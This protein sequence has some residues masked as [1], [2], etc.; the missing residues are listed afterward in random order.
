[1]AC[2]MSCRNV[3]VVNGWVDGQNCS[4]MHCSILFGDIDT[5]L[6]I[7]SFDIV[8]FLDHSMNWSI[9][10][11]YGFVELC[12]LFV[13]ISTIQ[14]GPGHFDSR[15]D[16]FSLNFMGIS[17]MLSDAYPAIGLSNSRFIFIVFG[18]RILVSG[19]IV[20]L[21]EIVGMGLWLCDKTISILGNFCL[22]LFKFI[23]GGD[24]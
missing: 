6:A 16:S 7:C 13:W 5:S 10:S 2:P 18:F 21:W 24:F 12:R 15:L 23:C 4:V 11:W 14:S 19:V 8:L 3:H 22:G 1:M 9:C 17:G 20:F